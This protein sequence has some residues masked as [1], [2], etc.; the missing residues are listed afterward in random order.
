[1]VVAVHI[2]RVKQDRPHVTCEAKIVCVQVSPLCAQCWHAS[3]KASAGT[4]VAGNRF[5]HSKR[6]CLDSLSRNFRDREQVWLTSA[7]TK[8]FAF[9]VYLVWIAY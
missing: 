7:N 3:E 6:V 4:F 2:L 9:V 8:A 5:C 1:M